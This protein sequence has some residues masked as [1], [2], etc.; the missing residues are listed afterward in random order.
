MAKKHFYLSWSYQREEFGRNGT[1][2][3]APDINFSDRRT[4]RL[5]FACGKLSRLVH[6]PDG[7]RR[8][9]EH[10]RE[11]TFIRRQLVEFLPMPGKQI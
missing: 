2:L 9:G 3:S 11:F 6:H 10:L 5:T 4:F 7:A 1:N 8:S